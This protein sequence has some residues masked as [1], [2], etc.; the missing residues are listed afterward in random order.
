[1]TGYSLRALIEEAGYFHLWLAATKR[2]TFFESDLEKAFFLLQLQRLLTSGW[3]GIDR[4]FPVEL[5]AFS[6]TP[7]G[8]HLL[9]YTQRKPLLEHLCHTLFQR[10]ADYLTYRGSNTPLDPLLIIDSLTGAHEALN[11]SREIHLLH[12]DWPRTHHSSIGYYLG[13]R[14]APWVRTQRL[15]ELFQHSPDN[16]HKLLE[17]RPTE[18]DR[19]FDFIE[20]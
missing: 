7:D 3:K 4:P 15:S 13:E 14:H 18:H 9:V 11:V 16:Y 5:L 1:M 8:A 19:I 20:T 10:Y 2:N 12:E 17:S 6:L